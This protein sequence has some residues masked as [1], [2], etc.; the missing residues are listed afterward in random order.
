MPSK[1]RSG[2]RPSQDRTDTRDTRETIDP[3]Y[4]RENIR[5][6]IYLF[7]YIDLCVCVCVRERERERVITDKESWKTEIKMEGR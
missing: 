7:I 6:N 3:F 5:R 2:N 1:R 4:N